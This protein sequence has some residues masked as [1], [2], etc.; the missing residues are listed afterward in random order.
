MHL[1]PPLTRQDWQRLERRE[2]GRPPRRRREQRHLVG[3]TRREE[4][5]EEA[6]ADVAL[7]AATSRVVR[8]RDVCDV[9]WHGHGTGSSCKVAHGAR[10]SLCSAQHN[11]RAPRPPQPARNGEGDDA[12]AVLLDRLQ[13]AEVPRC[14]EKKAAFTPSQATERQAAR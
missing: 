14:R 12:R 8:V 10:G 3:R 4:A 5:R 11:A 1:A 2:L 7:G 9:T 13:V 6:L